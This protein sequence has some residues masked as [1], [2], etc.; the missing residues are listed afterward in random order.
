M[1]LENVKV[2]MLLK[3]KFGNEYEVIEVNKNDDFQPVRVKCVKF[4][5]RVCF[6]TERDVIYRAGSMAWL[7]KDHSHVLSIDDDYGRFI[8]ETFYPDLSNAMFNEAVSV[9]LSISNYNYRNFVLGTQEA[10]SRIEITL[11]DLSLAENFLHRG[12]VSLYDTVFDHAYVPYE[13]LAFTD[14]K[15]C[16][17][18]KTRFRN[19]DNKTK[20]M[21]SMAWIPFYDGKSPDSDDVTTKDF[22]IMKG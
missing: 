5:K 12:N 22:M 11:R 9:K 7:L 6:K 2:G 3:D 13:V 14:D 17:R 8:K 19:A 21:E 10:I 1:K 4:V 16:L 20:Y 18:V 15:V